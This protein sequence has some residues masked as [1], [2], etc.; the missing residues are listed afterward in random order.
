MVNKYYALILGVYYKKFGGMN[1]EPLYVYQKG[2]RF[3]ISRVS[4]KSDLDAEEILRHLNNARKQLEDM[5]KG[6]EEFKR[7]IRRLEKF[8][9]SAKKIREEELV[10]AKNE[11]VGLG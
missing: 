7:D 10:K 5:E 2:K 4:E 8:E 1:M 9:S 3:V 11:R 6:I